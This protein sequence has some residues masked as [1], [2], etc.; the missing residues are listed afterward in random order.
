MYC[1]YLFYNTIIHY[2]FVLIVAKC[3]VNLISTVSTKLIPVVLIVAK[4]IVNSNVVKF[5]SNNKPY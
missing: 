4:C 1:K 3:I 5:N 2:F